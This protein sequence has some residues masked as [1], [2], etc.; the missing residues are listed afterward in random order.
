MSCTNK[1]C[2]IVDVDYGKSVLDNPE[3]L[4]GSEIPKEN[5]KNQRLRTLCLS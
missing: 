2:H 5:K 3:I 4:V 1:C